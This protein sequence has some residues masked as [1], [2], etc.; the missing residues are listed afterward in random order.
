MQ[1]NIKQLT[2]ILWTKMKQLHYLMKNCIF[3][4]SQMFNFKFDYF[5]C[6]K[7]YRFAVLKDFTSTRFDFYL[8][9]GT[10]TICQ[11]YTRKNTHCFLLAIDGNSF[12][13]LNF[14]ENEIPIPNTIE[15]LEILE[16]KIGKLLTFQ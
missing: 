6:Q 11:D 9:I 10:Y 1:K 12:S 13:A 15:D 3:C 7:C 4:D 5:E 2:I 16:D 14:F 8:N